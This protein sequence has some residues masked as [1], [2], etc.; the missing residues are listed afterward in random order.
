MTCRWQKLGLP[1]RPEV[2]DR[3]PKLMNHAVNPLPL[4]IEGDLYR[5]LYS[6]RDDANRF[7]FGAVDIDIVRRRVVEE[8]RQ[9][10]LEHGPEVASTRSVSASAAATKLAGYATCCSPFSV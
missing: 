6:A 5:F 7:S 8:H 1:Y 9:P 10:C 2:F 4:Q 3:H